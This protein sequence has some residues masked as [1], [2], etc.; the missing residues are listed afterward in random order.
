MEGQR[1]FLIY[2]CTIICFSFSSYKTVAYVS[3]LY[4]TAMLKLLKFW[5]LVGGN[6]FRVALGKL[7][8]FQEQSRSA[9]RN[10]MSTLVTVGTISVKYFSHLSLCMPEKYVFENVS[11]SHLH[12]RTR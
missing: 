7:I 2:F 12:W 3:N 9:S 4:V 5:F 1:Q 10:F 11:L 8:F 6:K